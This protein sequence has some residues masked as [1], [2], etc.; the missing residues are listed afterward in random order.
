MA[1][2]D[3]DGAGPRLV[4]ADIDAEG[5]WVSMAATEAP[6]LADWR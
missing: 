1:A 2:I 3:S 5:S 4:I 6:S